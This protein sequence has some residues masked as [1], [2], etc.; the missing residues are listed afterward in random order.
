MILA[1]LCELSLCIRNPCPKVSKGNST[2]NKNKLGKGTLSVE[3][4]LFA[5]HQE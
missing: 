3:A 4:M 1:L 5:M 2:Y